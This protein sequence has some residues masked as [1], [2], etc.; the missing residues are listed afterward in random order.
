M[1]FGSKVF[2]LQFE[3]YIDNF[4]A[5]NWKISRGDKAYRAYLVLLTFIAS[6]ENSFNFAIVA[7]FFFTV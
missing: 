4:R 5:R 7:P 2:S 3:N 1:V 6:P